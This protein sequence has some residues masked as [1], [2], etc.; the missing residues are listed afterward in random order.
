MTKVTDLHRRW[1]KESPHGLGN[2]WAEAADLG[3][4]E[5]SPAFPRGFPTT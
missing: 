2:S 1:S 5:K 4:K 3:A